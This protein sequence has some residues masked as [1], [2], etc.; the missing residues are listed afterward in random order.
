M[1]QSKDLLDKWIIGYT[2]DL[3]NSC[4]KGDELSLG[5]PINHTP[6]KDVYDGGRLGAAP[7]D[8]PES[9]LPSST[10]RAMAKM[11]HLLNPAMSPF[12]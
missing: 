9:A 1:L 2:E 12:Q 7:D 8:S 3:A 4:D 5:I 11:A 10:R 6:E